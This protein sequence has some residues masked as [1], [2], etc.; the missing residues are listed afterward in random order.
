M[1]SIKKFNKENDK[2]EVH[3]SSIASEIALLD[4][5]G[6]FKASNVEGA[7]RENAKKILEQEIKSNANND[8]IKTHSSMIREHSSKLAKH[9]EDIDDFGNLCCFYFHV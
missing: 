6:N 7:L 3:G 8:T 2:W 9:E 4:L 1:A 5:E